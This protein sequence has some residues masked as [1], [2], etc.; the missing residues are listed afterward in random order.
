MDSAMI[1]GSGPA[2]INGTSASQGQSHEAGSAAS[3]NNNN[4]TT[5]TNSNG[6]NNG[7]AASDHSSPQ[8]QRNRSQDSQQ[9]APETH[10][11]DADDVGMS[12]NES[13]ASKTT[14]KSGR[15][16]KSQRFY[17]T[18]F[19]PCGLSFTRSEHLARHIRKH[20]GERPFEC[21]CHRRFSRLDN[22]RQHAQTVHIHED[23]PLSSLA[24]TGARFQR[25]IRPDRTRAA[26]SGVRP[27]TGHLSA[28]RGHSKSFST[29]SIALGST[30]YGIHDD[31]QDLRGNMRNMRDMQGM[32]PRPPP[33]TTV[34]D[35]ARQQHQMEPAAYHSTPEGY[36]PSTPPEIATPTSTTFSNGPATP[37]WGSGRGDS[38]F[39]N[40]PHSMY[41]TTETPSRRLSVPSADAHFQSPQ[42]AHP[43][44][45][46]HMY[47]AS[48]SSNGGA[49]FFPSP[50][51]AS[52]HSL[53]PDISTV[54][55][56]P[57]RESFSSVGDERRRTWH[58]ASRDYGSAPNAPNAPRNGM[59]A[60]SGP[61]MSTSA[62]NITAHYQ[63]SGPQPPPPMTIAVRPDQQTNT[64]RLP[65]IDSLLQRP[66][67]A[68]R[69]L[70]SPM[71]LDSER[72]RHPQTAS[73]LILHS[74]VQQHSSHHQRPLSG[75]WDGL[76][77]GF[78]R[79]DLAN[80]LSPQ[81]PGREWNNHQNYPTD[82]RAQS[83]QSSVRFEPG[84]A[85][86]DPFASNSAGGGRAGYSRGHQY[87]M[88]APTVNG[89]T[90]RQ[91]RRQAW[92]DGPKR[93][94][95]GGSSGRVERMEHPNLAGGFSGFPAR[96]VP[97]TVHEYQAQGQEA[98]DN[99]EQ[100]RLYNDYRSGSSYSHQPGRRG[101][102][103]GIPTQ[104]RMS[105]AE[106][107]SYHG[108]D[109]LVAAVASESKNSTS[110]F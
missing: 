71:V 105:Q 8:M 18:D 72:E 96:G 29:S 90:S 100:E 75:Q 68:E 69:Q 32:R 21:H 62:G 42:S 48:A 3:I 73:Q 108:L 19:P 7:D 36:R 22:L 13:N 66:V 6:H 98:H 23:I 27:R 56:W 54:S 43:P 94:M 2:P 52:G 70:P 34:D 35:H 30:S 26:T 85:R 86:E 87:T 74:P 49:G 109:A 17:C 79:L 77:Q 37:Q 16:K 50:T 76:R 61:P 10:S 104:S 20:T 41:A 58:I 81:E 59:P 55:G 60:A 110:A 84:L 92:Y 103:P 64:V 91:A 39:G 101:P 102:S 97:Q 46:G 31:M 28:G 33:L 88:S 78:N 106:G 53:S 65:G 45:R 67:S 40:R 82:S 25:Q 80:Q 99:N 1:N 24:A 89:P 57:R 44:P 51:Q 38:P 47:S 107:N 93:A 11:D 5:T 14:H 12:D 4:T 83:Q 95:A 15:K 63:P 9:N